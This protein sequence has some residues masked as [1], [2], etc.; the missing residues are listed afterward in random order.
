[1]S[2]IDNLI[3]AAIGVA[4]ITAMNRFIYQDSIHIAVLYAVALVGA[5]WLGRGSVRLIRARRKKVHAI[6]D[7]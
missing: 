2:I 1:M 4:A 3:N 5:F 7:E 6:I